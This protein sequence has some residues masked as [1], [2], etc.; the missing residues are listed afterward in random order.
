MRHIYHPSSSP[1]S[2]PPSPLS[3]EALL[4]YPPVTGEPEAMTVLSYPTLEGTPASVA[5]ALGRKTEWEIVWTG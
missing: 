4:Y 3:S 1:P 2:Y 5:S